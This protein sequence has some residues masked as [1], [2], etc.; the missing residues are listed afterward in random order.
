M[1]GVGLVSCDVFFVGGACACMLMEL[2]LIPLKSSA[3]ASKWV[4]G[5]LWVQYISGKSF[6]LWPC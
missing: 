5:C 2:D 4:S 6:W 3:M 1:D